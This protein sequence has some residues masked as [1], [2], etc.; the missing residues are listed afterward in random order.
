[1]EKELLDQDRTTVSK[2][3]EILTFILNNERKITLSPWMFSKDKY[4]YLGREKK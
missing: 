3:G 4:F 1:V 2:E